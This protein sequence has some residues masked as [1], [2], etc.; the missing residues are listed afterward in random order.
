M[1]QPLHGRRVLKPEDIVVGAVE[2]RVGALERV[3]VVERV[4]RAE[5][6]QEHHRGQFPAVDLLV[7]AGLRLNDANVRR[8]E[9][10][11]VAPVS[12]E[13]HVVDD[14]VL[15][16]GVEV[17]LDLRGVLHALGREHR[18]GQP[19]VL[20]G[21]VADAD[22]VI[23]EPVHLARRRAGLGRPELRRQRQLANPRRGRRDRPGPVTGRPGRARA[24]HDDGQDGDREGARGAERDR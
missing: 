13:A 14:E 21:R 5:V 22:L 6:A 24:D 4:S 18:P 17:D 9:R 23:D 12:Q 1:A 20:D 3:G 7:E 15:V 19:V 10:E 2:D 16:G 11:D 8:P